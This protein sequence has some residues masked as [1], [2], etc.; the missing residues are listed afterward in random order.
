MEVGSGVAIA[1]LDMIN[2]ND[3]N[4][5]QNSNMKSLANV[6]DIICKKIIDSIPYRLDQ[7]LKNNV[8]AMISDKNYP[9]LEDINVIDKKVRFDT[10]ESQ[11]ENIPNTKNRAAEIKK[12]KFKSILS[13]NSKSL[14]KTEYEDDDNL[15]K[16][17][18]MKEKEDRSS[19]LSSQTSY[20]LKN[21]NNNVN[22][23]NNNN[24]DLNNDNLIKHT[25]QKSNSNDKNRKECKSNDSKRKDS[26]ESNHIVLPAIHNGSQS[27]IHQNNNNYDQTNQKINNGSN[28]PKLS[29][30]LITKLQRRKSKSVLNNFE[31]DIYQINQKNTN[32]SEKSSKSS[33][34]N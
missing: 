4:R 24:T 7:R 26:N 11:K 21:M 28:S 25:R 10:N 3:I 32:S 14:I 6:Q 23:I 15:P 5:I 31:R 9:F 22:Q 19:I 12:S 8:K 30:N 20:S 1:L 2:K 16:L 17:V 33:R 27:P 13:R 34:E 18:Q 29:D